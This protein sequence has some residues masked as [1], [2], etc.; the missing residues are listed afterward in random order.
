MNFEPGNKVVCNTDIFSDKIKMGD[1]LTVYKIVNHCYLMFNEKDAL[2]YHSG[3]FTIDKCYTRSQKIK[4][5][6]NNEIKKR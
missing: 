4:K 3:S 5:L 2:A 1:K 6:M